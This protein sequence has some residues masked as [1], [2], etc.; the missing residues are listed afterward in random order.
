MSVN[1]LTQD[2][3]RRIKERVECEADTAKEILMGGENYDGADGARSVRDL[4]RDTKRLI[5]EI[6]R[7]NQT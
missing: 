1:P 3:L 4:C 2:E 5:A 7:L 6:E